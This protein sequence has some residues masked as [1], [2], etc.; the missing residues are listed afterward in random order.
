MKPEFQFPV[1]YSRLLAVCQLSSAYKGGKWHEHKILEFFL[2]CLDF[3]AV[4]AK[5]ISAQP[6]QNQESWYDAMALNVESVP[7]IRR[8]WGG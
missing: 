7:R 3:Y 1:Y 8:V 5:F 4:F 6:I 2:A